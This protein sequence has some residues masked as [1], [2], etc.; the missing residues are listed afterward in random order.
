MNQIQKPIALREG[1][2][3]GVYSPSDALTG[4]RPDRVEAGCDRLAQAGFKTLLTPNVY[5]KDATMAGSV[6]QRISDIRMLLSDPAVK[7]IFASYGGK[8]CNQLIYDLPYD[9]I[10]RTKKVWMG[11]SDIAVLLNAI[12]AKTGLITFHGPNIVGKLNE[13]DH[14]ELRLVR[15][16]LI[17]AGFNLLGNP[18]HVNCKTLKQ[19]TATGKLFGGNLN[20]FVLGLVYSKI[21]LDTFNGGIFFWEDLGLTPREINQ[22]LTALRNIGFLDRISGMIVGDFITPE[23]ENR[24]T[25]DPF[26]AVLHPARGYKFPILY[27]PIF[28]H[29]RL[30]NPIFPIGAKCE[31][32]ADTFTL[33]L[34]EN[35]VIPR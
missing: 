28:G 14:W 32:N 12:T 18:S 4:Y 29:R 6:E 24:V 2:V 23:L 7:A 16:P 11:F 1:D 15:E 8:A 10:L 22:A 9:D 25:S 33:T 27:A 13:T 19:G 31:L 21:N 30:E 17:Q 20:C 34:L 26:E 5:A 3:I 35:C